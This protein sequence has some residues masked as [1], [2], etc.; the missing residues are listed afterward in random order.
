MILLKPTF[1]IY[2]FFQSA[3]HFKAIP[4]LHLK[5]FYPLW[6]VMA[7]GG[8]GNNAF[9]P[10]L[11]VFIYF[12]KGKEGASLLCSLFRL[13]LRIISDTMKF[14]ICSNKKNITDKFI[15]NTCAHLC[16]HTHQK[17]MKRT[18]L[19]VAR[20]WEVEFFLFSILYIMSLMSKYSFRV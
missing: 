9:S 11:P 10:C 18:L 3:S 19:W 16:A 4:R 12:S 14:L 15:L 8:G 7:W 13:C 5:A 2:S 1:T 6:K 17:A 20:L